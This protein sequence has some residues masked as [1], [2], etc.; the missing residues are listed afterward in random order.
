VGYALPVAPTRLQVILRVASAAIVVLAS[1]A[2]IVAAALVPAPA[3]ALPVVVL[4]C[5]GTPIAATYEL[6]RTLAARREPSAQ[7]RRDL[8]RLPE[9][10]HPLG[11]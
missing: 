9:T 1:A 8:D 5:V 4:A 7:L 6:A 3:G 10:P 11:F 2:L